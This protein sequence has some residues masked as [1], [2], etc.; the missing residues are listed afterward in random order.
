MNNTDQSTDSMLRDTMDP[1]P[2]LRG[3]HLICLH[4][5]NGEGYNQ[6]FVENLGNILS[7]AVHRE[8][9]IHLGPDDVCGKCPYLKQELCSYN[10]GADEG[11]REMDKRALDLLQLS[12]GMEVRWDTLREKIPGIFPEWF[13]AYCS[14]CGWKQACEKTA[15]YLN[16][17]VS[18]LPLEKR[19]V[20]E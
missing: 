10:K 2:R 14:S 19:T 4:F 3:H 15:S 12:P 18:L 11:I 20:H 8:V 5:F 13:E 9:K 1:L 7:I 6:E 17:R 16:L